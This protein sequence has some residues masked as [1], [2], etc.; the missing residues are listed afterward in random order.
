[1]ALWSSGFGGRR[2]ERGAAV[3]AQSRNIA[4]NLTM[5]NRSTPLAYVIS[6]GNQAGL[7]R[8]CVF[9]VEVNPLL[10]S[11]LGQGAVAVGAL[12]VMD[13]DDS[14]DDR[15]RFNERT[16]GSRS[17]LYFTVPTKV[18]SDLRRG[19]S[20]SLSPDA[21]MILSPIKTNLSTLTFSGNGA[22]SL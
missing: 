6:A 1:M 9:E 7:P 2:V 14:T 15:Q 10:V 8:G 19:P 17:L 3:I 13:S 11:P 18:H 20:G 5:S 4:L 16:W 21:P 12:I 22:T